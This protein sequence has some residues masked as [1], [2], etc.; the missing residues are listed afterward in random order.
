MLTRIIYIV[1]FC[2]NKPRA[3]VYDPLQ[4]KTRNAGK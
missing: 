1:T 4:R 2:L 3:F